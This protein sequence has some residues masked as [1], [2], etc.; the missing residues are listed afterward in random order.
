MYLVHKINE[1]LPTTRGLQSQEDPESLTSLREGSPQRP[2]HP[3]PTSP[4]ANVR[5]DGFCSLHHTPLGVRGR[6]DGAKKE[7][8]SNRKKEAQCVTRSEAAARCAIAYKAPPHWAATERSCH[9]RCTGSEEV[10]VTST[11]GTPEL[12]GASPTS[13]SRS[14]SRR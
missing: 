10:E 4:S 13:N 12:L 3:Q 6:P 7:P 5:K 8:P 9:S 11:P 14:D 2:L 1:K